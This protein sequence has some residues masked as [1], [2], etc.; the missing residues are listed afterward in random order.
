VQRIID[1]LLDGLLVTAP[2]I[3]QCLDQFELQAQRNRYFS[4]ATRGILSATGFDNSAASRTEPPSV[5]F[6][7]IRNR[8]VPL[9]LH[10]SAKSLHIGSTSTLLFGSAQVALCAASLGKSNRR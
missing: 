9:I 1:Q 2:V 5:R 8:I 7:A 6:E 10:L 4:N 3:V